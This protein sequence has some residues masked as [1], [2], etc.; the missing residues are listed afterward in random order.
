MNLS[1]YCVCLSSYVYYS[2]YSIKIFF[3]CTLYSIALKQFYEYFDQEHAFILLY[4]LYILFLLK[5]LKYTKVVFFFNIS[6]YVRMNHNN[7]KTV[8]VTAVIIV[9]NGKIIYE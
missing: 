9:V 8:V 7:S 5:I 6:E 1:E 2:L 4:A 3:Y